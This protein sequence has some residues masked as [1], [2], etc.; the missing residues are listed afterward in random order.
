MIVDARDV[1][2]VCECIST[3]SVVAMVVAMVD[4]AIALTASTLLNGSLHRS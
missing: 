3:F 2:F 1:S 4:A